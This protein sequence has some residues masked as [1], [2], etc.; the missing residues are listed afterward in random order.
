MANAATHQGLSQSEIEALNIRA[1]QV[2]ILYKQ[3]ATASFTSIV[4]ACLLATMQW[5]VIAQDTIITWLALMVIA[6]TVRF[7]SYLL[8]SKTKPDVLKIHVWEKAQ[9]FIT[10]LAG[11]AWG[12][13]GVLMFPEAGFEYQAGTLVVLTGMAAGAVTTLSALRRPVVT[14]LLL[15]LTPMTV[16][17]FLTGTDTAFLIGILLLM[18]I[19]FL[20]SAAN[21]GYIINFENISMRIKSDARE[22]QLRSSEYVTKQ[23]A[24][25]LE[26]IAKGVYAKLIY[27][28]IATLYEA[29]HEGMRCS[30]LELKG[31]KLIHGG[32]PS[33]PEQ[34]CKDVNGLEIGP[35]VGSCGTAAHTGKQVLVADIATD[36]KWAALKDATLL[37]GMRSA[38]SQPILDSSGKVLG[39]FCMYFDEVGLP[40]E[41]Q[42]AD[43]EAAAQLA[44]IVM[45]REQHE[46]SLR[47]FSQA[48]EQ[49]GESILITDAKGIIEYINPAFTK[50]TGYTAAELLGKT[51]R[52]LNS[53]FQDESYYQ[54]LWATITSGKVWTGSVIDKRKDGTSFPSI[55]SIA[56]I[57]NEQGEITNYVSIQQDMTEHQALENKFR[58]AQ[59]MEALGTLVGGIAHDFNNILA[60]M[61]GNLYL[62]KKSTEDRPDVQRKLSNVEDLSFRAADLIQQLLTFARRD[63]VTM[64][65]L[66]LATFIKE[67]LK[68]MRTTIPE[69]I[70]LRRDVCTDSLLINGDATQLQQALINLV[71]NARDAVE[72]VENPTITVRLSALATDSHFI[73]NHP[74]FLKG[75]Y[76]HLTVQD[77]GCG[78]PEEHL[79]HLFEPFFTT[80]EQGKGTGLGLAMVFGAVKTHLGY[81]EVES[82]QGEGSTFHLY[83]PLIDQEYRPTPA[84]NPS[85]IIN[86]NGELILL[87]DDEA[88]IR[89]TGKEVLE[90]LGYEVLL[91][92]DG[93]EAVDIFAKH[94][95][96][97]E[98]VVMDVVMPN[99]GGVEAVQQMMAL[100][101]N[102]NVIYAT[103]YDLEE[104]LPES[105]LASGIPVL[106]KPYDVKLLSQE[107]AKAISNSKE[108]TVPSWTI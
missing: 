52:E 5:H 32:A 78:I 62:A 73:E 15:V 43:L 9:F 18:Y 23:T 1:A 103:G 98:V 67:P 87:A 72:G 30:L 95:K 10:I 42:L 48:I 88:H 6:T 94:F 50:L 2:T 106:A 45:E 20:M 16:N 53:G 79:E 46:M 70:K 102:L 56:P 68:L 49:A 82:K 12:L 21:Q 58:Q 65:A 74:Y 77:N 81:V 83:I 33:L 97:V 91:A 64:K 34:F 29:R 36:S 96:R 80:K 61:T 108:E 69:N 89:T 7:S 85:P 104:A 93:Q 59:K 86:G 66:P 24:F 14:F 90:S 40:N 8:F 47:M 44:S 28:A 11:S 63:M 35:E 22:V 41:E 27:N 38:W 101:P 57:M 39:S 60:G 71:N 55:M 37:H 54:Q 25:I 3:A 105:V 76:A 31:N 51:P 92:K 100:R 107:I 75:V 17:F 84:A 99:L 13:A 19:T 4:V 26:M